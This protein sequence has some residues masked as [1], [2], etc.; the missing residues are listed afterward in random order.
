[1][2]TLLVNG[3]SHEV[4]AAADE[5]LLSVLRNRLDLTGTKYGCGEGQCGAC[6][7]LLDGRPARSC[8]TQ[9]G[10]VGARRITTIEGVEQDGKLH[11]VQQ[12]FLAKEAFQCGYCTPGMIMSAVAL[13]NSN[14]HPS[15][16]EIIHSLNGNICRCGTYPRIVSAV[17]YAESLQKG[18][19]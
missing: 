16:S 6:T 9:V 13:L 2:I 8:R 18:P 14:P 10:L 12:G 15:D 17:R 19:R 3:A 1:M 11:P 4:D 7:V 5:S